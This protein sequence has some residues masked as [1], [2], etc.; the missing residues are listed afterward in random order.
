MKNTFDGLTSRLDTAKERINDLEDI[1]IETA[2]TEMQRE[3][4]MGKK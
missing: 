3:K 1:S 2:Q 4:R